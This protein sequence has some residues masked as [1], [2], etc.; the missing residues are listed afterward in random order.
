M[1]HI[2]QISETVGGRLVGSEDD[3]I[4]QNLL[5]DSRRLDAA[6]LTLFFA[7]VSQRNDGH[8]YIEDLYQNGVRAFVVSKM[9][10][11]VHSDA[12]YLLVDDVLK[13]LQ[14]LAAYH[15]SQFNIPVIGITGSNGKT[16][17]KEWLAQLLSPDYNL[18][19]SPKSYNS[20]V[21][22]P[23]SVWRMDETHQMAIFEAGISKPDEMT[24]LQ[25]IIKPTIGIFTNIGQA[26]EENFISFMQKAGPC[27]SPPAVW[28]GS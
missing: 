3:R 7:L 23:L 16:I 1:Y 18:V 19:R 13:A 27:R 4:I 14:Q 5:I 28:P 17:V 15:R 21:G 10:E 12:C 22:V 8:K 9:P 24:A 25:K 2:K 20:Q 11:E 6:G 26:H